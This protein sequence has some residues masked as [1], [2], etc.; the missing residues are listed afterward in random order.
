VARAA[1]PQGE[2]AARSQPVE[3]EDRPVTGSA[4]SPAPA[5]RAEPVE[6]EARRAAVA[7][8]GAGGAAARAEAR[9]VR[10]G[11]S[12]AASCVPRRGRWSVAARPVALP[13][14][15]RLRTRSPSVA[16]ISAIS[17]ATPGTKRSGR[18]VRSR[19]RAERAEAAARPEA[20]DP[21]AVRRRAALAARPR[22]RSPA[23]ETTA[24]A[25]APGRRARTVFSDPSPPSRR[26]SASRAGA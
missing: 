10:R 22:G 14:Q 3:W 4:E 16:R 5:A 17:S 13:A 25:A 8:R 6:A 15:S 12:S 2:Q 21:E 1:P 20:A 19:V 24:P 7:S 26:G 18:A 9:N 23:A 11:R